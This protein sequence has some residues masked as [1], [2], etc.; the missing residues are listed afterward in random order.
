MVQEAIPSTFKF[1]YTTA[2]KKLRKLKKRIKVVP[3]GTSA[4]KTFGILPVLID[5]AT[6]KAGLEIS[7]VSESIP[8]LRRGAL[9]DFLKIMKATGRYIDENY[10]RTLLTY[11]FGNGSY[12]EFFSADQEDK[13]RGARRNILYVNEANNID[14]ESYYQLA[15]RTD[16][17]V[18]IDFNPTN[19]FWAHYE[20]E[21]DSDVDWLVLTYKDN[22]GLSDTIVKDIEKAL[23]K[24]YVDPNGDLHDPDNVIS[25][26]WANWWQVYGLGN[27]GR[28]E[29]VILTDWDKVK[30]IPT[31]A[32]LIGYGLDFGFTN[33]PT[34][35]VALYR[36]NGRYLWKELIYETGLKNADI[37]KKMKELGVK[38][39]DLVVADSSEP[40]SIAEINEYGFNVRKAVKGPDSIVFGLGVLQEEKFFVTSDSTNMIDE[41]RKY[42]WDRDKTGKS[43]NRPIDKYNHLIDAMRYI[44]TAKI[45]KQKRKKGGVRR[46]N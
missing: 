21:G 8:H 44:A 43:L 13:L 39:N 46:R 22:E 41:L 12:I 6:K 11:T 40:K 38:K 28:L 19:E 37:A 33:D 32:K 26:Y 27:L 45:S 16:Q 20:L 14:W 25:S 34:A 36:H 30:E 17:E 18:W 1:K 31:D 2:I 15:I 23:F 7:V 9:K 10:N 24:A 4:G 42:S 29:G 3:G 35:L 5:K